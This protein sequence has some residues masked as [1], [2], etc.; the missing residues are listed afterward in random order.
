MSRDRGVCV[1][2]APGLGVEVFR[3]PEGGYGAGLAAVLI[4]G[5]RRGC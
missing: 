1:W 4:V 2:G 3:R 5:W